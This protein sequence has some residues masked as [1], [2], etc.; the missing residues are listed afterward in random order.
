MKFRPDAF[1]VTGRSMLVKSVNYRVIERNEST[2]EHCIDDEF[3]RMTYDSH[4][5][6]P[7]IQYR[8][9]LSYFHDLSESFDSSTNSK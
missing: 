4:K 9:S 2:R 1:D 7:S 5:E 8:E 6:D 3:I